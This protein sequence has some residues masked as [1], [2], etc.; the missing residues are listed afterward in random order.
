MLARKYR[1]S[2]IYIQEISTTSFECFIGY[3]SDEISFDQTI[4]VL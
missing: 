2:D 4:T 1:Q 3:R